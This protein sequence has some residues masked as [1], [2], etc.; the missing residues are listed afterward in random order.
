MNKQGHIFMTLII[1][2]AFFMFGILMIGLI[3]PDISIARTAD[4]LD[5]SNVNITDGNKLA[6]LG[7]DIIVPTFIISLVLIAAGGVILKL[8]GNLE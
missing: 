4:N 1:S 7:V 6:C 8:T 3:F 5:C 2:L